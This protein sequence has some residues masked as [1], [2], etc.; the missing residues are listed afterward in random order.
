MVDPRR[1][2]TP[3][4]LVGTA[5]ILF[6]L[7]DVVTSL[8]P[9]AVL[10]PRWRVAAFGVTSNALLLPMTGLLILFVTAF[11]AGHRRFRQT[12]GVTTM[13]LSL[14][15][16]ALLII[17]GLDALQTR[18]AIRPELRASFTFASVG[19]AIKFFLAT[20]ILFFFGLSSRRISA[21]SP[22]RTGDVPLFTADP[23]SSPRRSNS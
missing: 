5:L 21:A 20:I 10:E 18:P 8:V 22:I 2:A 12:I 6:P 13:V 1:I 11:M 16:L 3:A 9:W 23:A 14:L 15:C 4:Y 19:S 7:A 17:F